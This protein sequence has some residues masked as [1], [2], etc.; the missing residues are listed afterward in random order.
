MFSYRESLWPQINLVPKLSLFLHRWHIRVVQKE[1]GFYSK[2]EGHSETLMSLH[3]PSCSGNAKEIEWQSSPRIWVTLTW[4]FKVLFIRRDQTE[5]SGQSRGKIITVKVTVAWILL[6]TFPPASMQLPCPLAA[7]LEGL[8]FWEV[9]RDLKAAAEG[10]PT[11][12]QAPANMT[13]CLHGPR[14]WIWRHETPSSFPVSRWLRKV[15]VLGRF[16][17]PRQP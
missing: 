2:Y 3:G 6:R 8:A 15:N 13:A 9:I 14:H 12:R 7:A 16:R 5:V 10:H 11:G 1:E 4:I 17:M